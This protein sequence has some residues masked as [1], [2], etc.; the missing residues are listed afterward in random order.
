[1]Q[2]K[3]PFGKRRLQPR[4]R[5]APHRRE[6]LGGRWHRGG[7]SRR[8]LTW[9]CPPTVAADCGCQQEPSSRNDSAG[10]C[11]CVL[12]GPWLAQKSGTG[13]RRTTPC[14]A[15]CALGRAPG[16][17]RLRRDRQRTGRGMQS[18]RPWIVPEGRGKTLI[19]PGLG[20]PNTRR[21]AWEAQLLQRPKPSEV[22]CLRYLIAI[23][24]FRRLTH[25]V[26]FLRLLS[27]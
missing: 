12:M 5:P 18:P 20:R 22:L 27:R 24:R 3:W 25:F 26:A 1:M 23:R 6:L 17:P 7:T 11:S 16:K 10:D 8:Y 21:P 15:G 2:Q 9:V 4:S 14:A 13:W 19:P